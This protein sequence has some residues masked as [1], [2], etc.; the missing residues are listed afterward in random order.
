MSNDDDDDASGEFIQNLKWISGRG[1][2]L[3]SKLKTH[4]F[5]VQSIDELLNFWTF[6]L[7]FKIDYD[8]HHLLYPSDYVKMEIANN[9]N[10]KKLWHIQ[11]LY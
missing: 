2:N 3:I 8:H 9:N 6:R 4:L 7:N 10:N 5:N 1:P 11:N